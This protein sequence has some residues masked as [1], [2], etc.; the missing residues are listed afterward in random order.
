MKRYKFIILFAVFVAVVGCK[1][2]KT[3]AK[4]SPEKVNTHSIAHKKTKKQVRHAIKKQARMKQTGLIN[5]N[6][7][8]K[9]MAKPIVR[10]AP[11]I[12]PGQLAR[13]ALKRPLQNKIIVRHTKT[14]KKI[15]PDVRLLLTVADMEDLGL[16]PG[17]YNR[18]V[19]QGKLP[20]PDYDSLN[21]RLKK[22]NFGI[23]I[24]VWAFKNRQQTKAKYRNIFASLPNART[25]DPIEG[26]TLFA[27][28][29]GV[30]YIGFMHPR[31]K[32]VI[33]LT[34][35]KKLCSSDKLYEIAKRVSGHLD[36]LSH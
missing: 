28:W 2:K 8:K 9:N 25:I 4:K 30:I 27:Y 19:L 21:Y 20:G 23:S 6:M 35:S 3:D 1:K 12:R 16:K 14:T 22:H 36:M 26:D 17:Q 31:Q 5:R 10:E 29:G 15:V 18:V 11:H 24:Q 32:V 33:N 7:I 34:C 13:P